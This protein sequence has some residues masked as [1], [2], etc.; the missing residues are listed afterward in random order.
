MMIRSVT[1]FLLLSFFLS[2]SPGQP[3][4]K[5]FVAWREDAAND[6]ALRTRATMINRGAYKKLLLRKKRD[7]IVSLLGPADFERE[8][9]LMYELGSELITRY[10]LEITFDEDDCALNVEVQAW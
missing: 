9:K 8:S 6:P 5:T 1:S 2:C 10:T 3:L 7:Q 4:T